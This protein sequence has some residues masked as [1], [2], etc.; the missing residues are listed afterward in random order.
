MGELNEFCVSSCFYF[1]CQKNN[2]LRVKTARLVGRQ[3]LKAYSGWKATAAMLDVERERNKAIADKLKAEKGIERW[4]GNVLVADDEGEVAA[5]I[6][7]SEA[8]QPRAASL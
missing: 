4:K 7:A 8:E 3:N 1:H 2:E 6:E 5:A